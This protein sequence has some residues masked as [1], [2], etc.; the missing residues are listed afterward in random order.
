MSPALTRQSDPHGTVA[1]AA[2]R[3]VEHVRPPADPLALDPLSP[4]VGRP[5]R[6]TQSPADPLALDPLGPIPRFNRAR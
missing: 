4:V 6:Y 3:P 2:A 5:T 1:Y